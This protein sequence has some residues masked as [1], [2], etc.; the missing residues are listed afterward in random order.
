MPTTISVIL[1]TNQPPSIVMLEPIAEAV[2]N[3]GDDLNLSATAHDPDARP[4]DVPL[5]FEWTMRLSDSITTAAVVASVGQTVL[6]DLQRGEWQLR[7][8]VTDMWGGTASVSRIIIVDASDNDGDYNSTCPVDGLS[9]W[10]DVTSNNYCGPDIYDLDDDN[11]G[12][13][14]ERDAFPLDECATTDTDDDGKP[15]DLIPGCEVS[16]LEVDDD[17]DNDGVLDTE[18]ADPKD[19]RVTS[20]GGVDSDSLI[21]RLLSPEVLI[22]LLIIVVVLLFVFLRAG[23]KR[24][25]QQIKDSSWIET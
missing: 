7:V 8:T 15:D 12:V 9:K 6:M 17:D 11:D 21:V 14:D 18:D 13:L 1:S 5:A 2:I 20:V 25:D 10:F 22:P 23:G 19:P 3:E 4:G 24:E 16:P